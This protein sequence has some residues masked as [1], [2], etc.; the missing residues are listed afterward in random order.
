VNEAPPL[1]TGDFPPAA[2]LLTAAFLL[3]S[4]STSRL[5]RLRIQMKMPPAIAEAA[6]A[7]TT[8]PAAMPALF[9]PEDFF[10]VIAAAAELEA[11][12]ALVAWTVTV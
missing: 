6:S 7:P 8:T 5:L 3:Y 11:A 12:A 4:S 1:L 2:K 9:G 10:S